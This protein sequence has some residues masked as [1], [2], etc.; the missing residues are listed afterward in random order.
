MLTLHTAPLL[1][2][3]DGTPATA[4]GA[5]AV[6]G[7]RITALGP[8]A[9]LRATYPGARVREWPGRLAPARVHTG[10]LPPAPSPRE[11]VHALFAAG[12]T[13]LLV[14]GPLGPA[15]REAAVRGGLRLVASAAPTPLAPQARADLCVTTDDGECVATV[16]AGRLVHRRR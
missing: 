1:D 12:A 4:G 9:A 6:S 16:C 7:D 5:V 15:L 2:A 11:T 3:G 14:E 10:P 8:L 13:A